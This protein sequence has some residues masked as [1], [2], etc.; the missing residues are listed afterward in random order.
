MKRLWNRNFFLMFSLSIMLS[1][2]M[3][4][5][6]GKSEPTSV[7]QS[8]DFNFDQSTGDF[9]F[10]AVDNADY[11]CV[12]VNAIGEDGTE[13]SGYSAASQRLKGT[14]SISGNADISALPFGQYNVKL[15]TFVDEKSYKA[16]DPVVVPIEI[17]GKLDTP[18]F[19]YSQNGTTVTVTLSSTSLS[20]YS[21]SQKLTSWTINVYDA[22]GN[23]VTSDTI[24]KD[25]LTMQQWGPNINFSGNTKDLTLSEGSY[26]ISVTADGD[27]KYAEVSDESEKLDLVVAADTTTEAK[28]ANYPADQGGMPPM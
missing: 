25:D 15:I 6:C 1:F 21:K 28:T 8:S 13:A 23:V 17:S 11:Y 16:P 18:E 22:S 10:T 2:T 19:K 24:S 26:K 9:S 20:T 3:L 7:T 5:G 4:T 27:G 14:G 12:W